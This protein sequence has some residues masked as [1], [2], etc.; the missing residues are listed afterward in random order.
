MTARWRVELL[1]TIWM[2]FLLVVT[3]VG[4]IMSILCQATT[5][6]TTG[7]AWM[8]VDEHAIRN[9]EDA[10]GWIIVYG[11]QEADSEAP[12]APCVNNKLFRTKEEALRHALQVNPSWRPMVK[13]LRWA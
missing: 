2:A 11:F 13:A 5:L 8:N 4:V 9:G 6:Q 3:V 10:A 1:A 7:E 12:F